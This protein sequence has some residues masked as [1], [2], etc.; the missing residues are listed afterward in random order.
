LRHLDEQQINIYVTYESSEPVSFKRFKEIW[1]DVLGVKH[2]QHYD[3]YKNGVAIVDDD[4]EISENIYND[5]EVT[6]NLNIKEAMLSY[7]KVT[8]RII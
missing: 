4:V 2:K 6:V 7:K 1:E 8:S 5:Y 3:L